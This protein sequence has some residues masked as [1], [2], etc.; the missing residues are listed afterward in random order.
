[1]IRHVDGTA[2]VI[3]REGHR[4]PMPAALLA[5]VTELATRV[6]A[7]IGWAIDDA[8]QIWLITRS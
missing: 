2:K 3:E 5:K 4:E 8:D 6:R 1:M 7:D